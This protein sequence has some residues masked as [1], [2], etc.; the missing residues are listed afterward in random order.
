[1]LLA[2]SQDT[3]N[4]D[5]LVATSSAIT[6][7]RREPHPPAKCAGKIASSCVAWQVCLCAS[8]VSAECTTVATSHHGVY[9]RHSGVVAAEQIGRCERYGGIM[10]QNT[11]VIASCCSQRKAAT[12]MTGATCVSAKNEK[13]E[14]RRASGCSVNFLGELVGDMLKRWVGCECCVIRLT[15]QRS[16]D[17]EQ[18]CLSRLARLLATV[19]SDHVSKGWI[20]S[21]HWISTVK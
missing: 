7:R 17:S 12:N 11:V 18:D 9:L 1:M 4:C 19:R 16:L 20:K 6:H 5:I 15:A 2:S 3:F 14:L 10:K 13:N 21:H 8:R